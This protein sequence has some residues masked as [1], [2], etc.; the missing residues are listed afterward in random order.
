MNRAA[1]TAFIIDLLGVAFVAAI[2]FCSA[3]KISSMVVGLAAWTTSPFGMGAVIAYLGRLRMGGIMFAMLSSLLAIVSAFAYFYGLFLR[4]DPFSGA[5]LL[6]IP[7]AHWIMLILIGFFS[8]AIPSES[9]Y[10]EGA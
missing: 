4:P 9:E 6:A 10:E 3:D 2:V 1:I 7:I 8:A 5:L